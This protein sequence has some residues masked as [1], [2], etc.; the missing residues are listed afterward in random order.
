MHAAASKTGVGLIAAGADAKL[1]F[2]LYCPRELDTSAADRARLQASSL[3]M[4]QVL[5]M[6]QQPAS[7][8]APA[9]LVCNIVLPFVEP[10]M[11]TLYGGASTVSLFTV[12]ATAC[13]LTV[14]TRTAAHT[15]T[16]QETSH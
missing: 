3:S 8:Y 12:A 7:A 5:R 1:K 13:T 2:G 11:S 14:G 15:D 6:K 9:L 16:K 10:V 4:P